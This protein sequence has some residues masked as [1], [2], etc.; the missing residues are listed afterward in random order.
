MEANNDPNSQQQFTQSLGDQVSSIEQEARMVLPGVQALFGFQLMVVF[1]SGFKQSLSSLEQVFHLISLLL[2]AISAVL[3]VAPAAYHRQANHQ[4]SLHFIAL[5]S[6]F[7][8]WA[9]APLALGT[10]IDIFLVSKVIVHSNFISGII[11]GIV[12]GIYCWTW[13]IYPNIHGKKNRLL[14][15][16]PL[17]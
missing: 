3:V 16:K 1:N 7:L 11:T 12:S 2:V 8:A 6:H 5:S 14:P 13:F 9:L 4:I 10:C 15:T 17:E